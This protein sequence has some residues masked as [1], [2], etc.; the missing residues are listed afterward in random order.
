MSSNI[1]T[2]VSVDGFYYSI[3]TAVNHEFGKIPEVRIPLNNL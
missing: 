3:K 1:R 2:C